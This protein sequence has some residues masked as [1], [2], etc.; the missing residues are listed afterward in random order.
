MVSIETNYYP[1]DSRQ[2]QS[3]ASGTTTELFI[4]PLSANFQ[5]RNFSFR[6]STATVEAAET[7]FSDFSNFKR[8]LMVLEGELLVT[9]EGHYSKL[10]RQFDQDLFDGGWK[11]NSKGKVRDFNVIFNEAVNAS[12]FH[13]VLDSSEVKVIELNHQFVF[14]YVFSGVFECSGHLLNQ[15]DFMQLNAQ[16]AATISINCL[17]QGVLVCVEIDIVV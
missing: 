15:G 5:Q 9:H 2:P 3:W 10:L 16:Q 14:F 6:I 13:V 17:N 4:Y 7:T 8:I 1:R 12:V 11:T